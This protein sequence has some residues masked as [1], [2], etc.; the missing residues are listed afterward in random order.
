MGH[1]ER[2]KSL[3]GARVGVFNLIKKNYETSRCRIY[4]LRSCLCLTSR[5]VDKNVTRVTFFEKSVVSN[6]I[7]L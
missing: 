3:F 1:I 2:D 6:K 5:A 4:L 7:S